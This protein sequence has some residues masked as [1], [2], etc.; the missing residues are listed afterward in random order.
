M[1]ISDLGSQISNLD[2]RS[3]K[4]GEPSVIARMKAKGLRCSFCDR[5][6]GE[7]AKM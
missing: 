7:G 3:Q 6:Q 2:L 5:A 4:L 1:A